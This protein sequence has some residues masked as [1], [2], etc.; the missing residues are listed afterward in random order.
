M[1]RTPIFTIIILIGVGFF[2]GLLFADITH[3]L[4]VG[5]NEESVKLAQGYYHVM[6]IKSKQQGPVLLVVVGIIGMCCLRQLF[7][8]RNKGLLALFILTLG[9]LLYL[10]VDVLRSEI[11]LTADKAVVAR[12][13]LQRIR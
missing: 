8:T 11:L 1:K 12:P 9:A 10:F 5:E 7:A 3:D 2:L 4:Q 6:I 13:L